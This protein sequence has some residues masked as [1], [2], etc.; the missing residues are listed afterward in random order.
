MKKVKKPR[1][2]NYVSPNEEFDIEDFKRIRGKFFN[3]F[4]VK[5]IKMPKY[6]Y[7]LSN[8]IK[9]VDKVDNI[10]IQAKLYIKGSHTIADLKTEFENNKKTKSEEPS[11]WISIISTTIRN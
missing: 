2:E 9:H 10:F 8:K 6:F 11:K 3:L 4:E 7:L 5:N 1:I